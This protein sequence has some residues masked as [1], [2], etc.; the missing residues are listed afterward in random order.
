MADGFAQAVLDELERDA[1]AAAG[2]AVDDLAAVGRQAP[3][4]D[5]LGRAAGGAAY[6]GAMQDVGAQ[7]VFPL[8]PQCL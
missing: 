4:G 1:A 7:H 5:V 2:A 6:G 8:I 3:M